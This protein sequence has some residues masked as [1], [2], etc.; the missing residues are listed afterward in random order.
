MKKTANVLLK[1]TNSNNNPELLQATSYG[2]PAPKTAL[3]IKQ[4]K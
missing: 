2:V 4:D 3:Q 1:K